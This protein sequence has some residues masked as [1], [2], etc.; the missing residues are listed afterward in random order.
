MFKMIKN[1]FS[2]IE[3]QANLHWCESTSLYFSVWTYWGS[4][5]ILF[6]R[7][8]YNINIFSNISGLLQRTQFWPE[9]EFVNLF[10][11]AD[12]WENELWNERPLY[13]K[14]IHK[15]IPPASHED[16]KNVNLREITVLFYIDFIPIIPTRVVRFPYLINIHSNFNLKPLLSLQSKSKV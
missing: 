14:S 8:I 10:T 4:H 11:S 16:Y 7:L 15:C 1:L 6:I 3:L 9:V 2:L 5:S 13:N 12:L